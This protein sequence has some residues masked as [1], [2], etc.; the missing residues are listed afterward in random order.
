ML[1]V[2]RLVSSSVNHDGLAETAEGTIQKQDRV[3]ANSESALLKN[4][5]SSGEGEQGEVQLTFAAANAR[6]V[7]RVRNVAKQKL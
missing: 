7:L 1:S 4:P 3:T 6:G 2:H 5:M